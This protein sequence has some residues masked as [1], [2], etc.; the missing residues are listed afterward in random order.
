[1]ATLGI[2]YIGC[3]IDAE[4][5][6]YCMKTDALLGDGMGK[7]VIGAGS[8]RPWVAEIK[9]R[10]PTFKYERKFVSAKTDY[11]GSSSTGNRGVKLW[12]LLETGRIYQVKHK[13]SW[14]AVERYFCEVAD[15]GS[16][17][18]LTAEEVE[19]WLN[20]D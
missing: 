20:R 18:K 5:K 17:R 10:H 13:T 1:M 19:T 14:K 2:E 11:K 9:G 6:F 12:F 7:R 15:D 4:M 3:G 16:I 8:D